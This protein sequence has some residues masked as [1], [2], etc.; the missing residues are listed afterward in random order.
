ME[1]ADKGVVIIWKG[2]MPDKERSDTAELHQAVRLKLVAG[3][4]FSDPQDLQVLL[5]P[6]VPKQMVKKKGW[7]KIGLKN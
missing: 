5:L 1:A 7:K 6:S 2:Q 3:F 4:A